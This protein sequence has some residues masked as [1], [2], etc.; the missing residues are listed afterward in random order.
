MTPTSPDL[1]Q[2]EVEDSELPGDRI[3]WK[4][5]E[6]LGTMRWKS[7]KFPG[8]GKKLDTT[9]LVHHGLPCQ[10]ALCTPYPG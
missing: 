7:V 6:L 5:I 1:L 8:G 4:G 10:V 9:G 3:H 2:G